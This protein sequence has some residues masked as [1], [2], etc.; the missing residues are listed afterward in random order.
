MALSRRHGFTFHLYFDPE[1]ML[2]FEAHR[3]RDGA[4][5]EFS[6]IDDTDVGIGIDDAVDRWIAGQLEEQFDHVS[7]ETC[8]CCGQ[9]CQQAQLTDDGIDPRDEV[10]YRF[11]LCPT[12]ADRFR[13]QNPW[14][15]EYDGTTP[16]DDNEDW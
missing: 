7:I 15:V 16:Y 12:C 14:I 9:R 10:A 4:V 11:D 8:R 5:L 6:R 13:T 1:G 2:W 3:D